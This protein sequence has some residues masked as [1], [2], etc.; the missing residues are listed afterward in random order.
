MRLIVPIIGYSET[1]NVPTD[2]TKWMVDDFKK[3]K[4][5]CHN[6]VHANLHHQCLQEKWDTLAHARKAEFW[7]RSESYFYIQTSFGV[8]HRQVDTPVV[9]KDNA[10]NANNNVCE[11]TVQVLVP[12][13][14]GL[15]CCSCGLWQRWW[16]C[17]AGLSAAL[18]P[19]L[20]CSSKRWKRA[21]INLVQESGYVTA[22][23]SVWEAANT[24]WLICS[25][26]NG[27]IRLI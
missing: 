14:P 18:Y 22:D 5:A 27:L 20:H 7:S 26:P 21:G 11:G 24:T 10:N 9:W 4:V 3:G 25:L 13:T 1:V 12:G 19:S 23:V 16:S 17:P 15:W 6:A 8:M 2:L